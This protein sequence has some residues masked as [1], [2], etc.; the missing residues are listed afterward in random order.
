MRR[1]GRVEL[2][3]HL[4]RIALQV[5]DLGLKRGLRRLLLGH[6]LLHLEDAAFELQLEL[7][8]VH[9]PSRD[10]PTGWRRRSHTQRRLRVRLRVDRVGR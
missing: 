4:L 2:L 5:L 1:D 9:G 10:N 6:P 3:P 8:L 7:H